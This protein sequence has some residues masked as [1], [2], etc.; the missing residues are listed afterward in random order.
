MNYVENWIG[1]GDSTYFAIKIEFW[2]DETKGFEGSQV[3][4][5]ETYGDGMGHITLL[6]GGMK[7][8]IRP[9]LLRKCR[10]VSCD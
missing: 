3:H 6:F 5:S 1:F 8:H 10:N 7:S 4:K 2:D 9:D